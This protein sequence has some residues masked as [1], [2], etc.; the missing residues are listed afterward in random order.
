MKAIAYIRVSTEEQAAEG[1]SLDAQDRAVRAYA[2]MRGM[3]LTEVVIDPGVSA[4]KPL[5]DREGGRRVLEAVRRRK[6]DAVVAYKLDRLFRDCAD[7]LT[8]TRQW[9]HAAISLHLIDLGGQSIDTS[10]AMGRFFLTVMAGA[11]EMERNLI[12]ERTSSAMQFMRSRNEYTGGNAPYGW[13]LTADG[14]LVANEAEGQVITEARALHDSGLSLRAV[15]GQL[16][17][18]GYRPRSGKGFHASQIRN[19]VKAA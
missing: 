2:A 11:A 12:R 6:V 13:D 10:T 1:V 8:V 3:E 18:R 7:C 16:A 4:G 17:A 14:A 9:D 5:A 15:A 19:M